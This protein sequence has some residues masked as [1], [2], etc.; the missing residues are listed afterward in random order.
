MTEGLDADG[1]RVLLAQRPPG[2]RVQA[3]EV[4]GVQPGKN[5]AA[6]STE[7]GRHLIQAGS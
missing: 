3:Q 2:D 4:R 1:Q 6:I 5:L 7:R